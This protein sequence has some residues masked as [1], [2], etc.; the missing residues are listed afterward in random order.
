MLKDRLKNESTKRPVYYAM[1][2]LLVAL[3]CISVP[4]GF[5]GEEYSKI[6]GA[7][8]RVVFAAIGITLAIMFGFLNEFKPHII[9]LKAADVFFVAL[10]IAVNNFPLVT[11]FKG[12]VMVSA[13]AGEW[14]EYLF[15]CLSVGF[16][17][18]IFFRGLIFLLLKRYFPDTKKGLFFALAASSLLFGAVHLI[19][20]GSSSPGAVFMQIGYSTLIGLLMSVVLVFTES[21]IYPALLHTVY[22]IGGMLISNLGDGNIWTREQIICTAVVAVA[23][24]AWIAF[25]FL[26]K[27]PDTKNA[28]LKAASADLPDESN[29]SQE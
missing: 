15:F 27:K 10:I 21:V 17:E 8:L 6:I 1:I 28:D 9:K 5:F 20:L 22:N 2:S 7:S 26:T 19:N 13:N 11:L 16:F 3:L 12:Q 24:S 23:G 18:E 25:R 14:A 29:H 4:A